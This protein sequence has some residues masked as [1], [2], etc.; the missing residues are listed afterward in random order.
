MKIA[1]I[2]GTGFGESLVAGTPETVET[3]YGAAL[4][5]RGELGGGRELVFLAR[6]GPGHRLPP[7]RINHRAN[8]AALRSLGVGAVLATAAVGSLRRRW[9]PATSWFWMTFW[10][11]P[12]VAR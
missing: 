8:V 9:P 2:G 5:T 1:I 7:H 6:H 3:E 11:S 10:T 4:V 12:R